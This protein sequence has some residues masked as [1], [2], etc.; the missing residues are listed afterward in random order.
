MQRNLAEKVTEHHVD[1]EV[2]KGRRSVL[3]EAQRTDVRLRQKRDVV[4]MEKDLTRQRAKVEQEV[5]HARQK[6][7]QFLEEKRRMIQE[8]EMV[9]HCIRQKISIARAVLR[10]NT[11]ERGNQ[12]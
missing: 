4:D 8:K 11:C 7:A 9:S 6:H 2:V 10:Y 1:R 3:L 5:H 12:Q